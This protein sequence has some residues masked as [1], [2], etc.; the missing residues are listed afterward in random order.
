[1]IPSGGLLSSRGKTEILKLMTLTRGHSHQ[2]IRVVKTTRVNQSINF[3]SI[4][5]NVLGRD[6]YNSFVF[7][8][9]LVCIVLWD[10]INCPKK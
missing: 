1:M 9:Y 4:P 8:V 6:T 2:L 7:S 5:Q 10:I 3:V